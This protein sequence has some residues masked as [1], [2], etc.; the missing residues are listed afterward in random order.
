LGRYKGA[1]DKAKILAFVEK[2]AMLLGL[3]DTPVEE[4]QKLVSALSDA[5]KLAQE[6][7]SQCEAE[8]AKA[9]TAVAQLVA[10]DA[11]I[12]ALTQSLAEAL[13]DREATADSLE[14]VLDFLVK[15][16]KA[17]VSL[18]D[19]TN[20]LDVLLGWFDTIVSDAQ[21]TQIVKL[22]LT[23][24]PDDIE[25]VNDPSLED[26]EPL[27]KVPVAK[28]GTFDKNIVM[29]YHE[30]L[31][32]YNETSANQWLFKLKSDGIVSADFDPTQYELNSK[33]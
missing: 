13:K 15:D 33:E 14:S 8:K 7:R 27:K 19:S 5:N 3:D 20:R 25:L 32:D 22:N 17:E 26:E 11:E 10:K 29:K 12:A 23:P 4:V 6:L 31:N 28:L 24:H 9:E 30:L 1:G 16:K 18:E 21:S 2:K